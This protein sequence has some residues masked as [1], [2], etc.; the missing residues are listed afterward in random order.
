MGD[1][2]RITSW[3]DVD[4]HVLY[5]KR[6][7]SEEDAWPVLVNTSGALLTASASVS[8]N[9][10]SGTLTA[11]LGTLVPATANVA[12]KVYAFSLTTT[13]ATAL[14]VAFM[15][16]TTRL[17]QVQLMAPAGA[18][19]GANLAN[20]TTSPLFSTTLTNTSLTLSCSSALL[21]HWSIAYIQE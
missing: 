20:P 4:A 16:G 21:V 2:K 10:S 11:T 17:W 7:L 19:A 5:A 14:V 6:A 15:A 12:T 8:T 3:S 13:S 18:S 1:Q 9:S